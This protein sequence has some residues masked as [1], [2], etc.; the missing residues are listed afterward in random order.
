MHKQKEHYSNYA[1]IADAMQIC[2][3][4]F[5]FPVHILLAIAYDW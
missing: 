1:N 5:I 4:V 2:A 3:P